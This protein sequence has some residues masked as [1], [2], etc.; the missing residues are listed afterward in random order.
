M[1][2][3]SSLP[4]TQSALRYMSHTLAD[5]SGYHTRCQLLF[6]KKITRNSLEEQ[7]WGSVSS[8]RTLQHGGCR[9]PGIKPS[10]FC[11][12]EDPLQ[13][14][15]FLIYTLLRRDIRK[16]TKNL[17]DNKV[18]VFRQSIECR[19]ECICK[20]YF[21]ALQSLELCRPT[22]KCLFKGFQLVKLGNG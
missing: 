3:L 12:V 17:T 10:I 21:A 8:P 2:H 4:T 1:Q 9:E 5:D 20:V 18:M 15:L 16:E 6:R 19:C 13:L 7:F 22:T 14:P 11:I